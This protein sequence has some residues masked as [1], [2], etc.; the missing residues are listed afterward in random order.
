MEFNLFFFTRTNKAN[1]A[2]WLYG[3]SQISVTLIARTKN[4]KIKLQTI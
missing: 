2:K 4:K 3:A 1:S